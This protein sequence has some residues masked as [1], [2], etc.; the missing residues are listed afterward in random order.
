MSKVVLFPTPSSNDSGGGSHADEVARAIKTLLDPLPP[1]EQEQVIR[2]L[3]EALRSETAPKA[4]DVLNTIV[5]L[6]PKQRDW[7]VQAIKKEV[8]DRGI[9]ASD[10]SI[11]NAIGYLTRKGRMRRIGYGQYI[12]DGIQVTT[13][14]E[15]GGAPLYP[16]SEHGD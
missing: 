15:F 7:S 2:K 14:D 13:A 12:V 1:A 10:K 9:E 3:A 8:E 6:L 4:G 16:A 11:Y 5:R